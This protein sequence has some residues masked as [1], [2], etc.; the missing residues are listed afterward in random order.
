MILSPKNFSKIIG[1]FKKFKYVYSL[2]RN[3][4]EGDLARGL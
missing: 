4:I 3:K 1:P 2:A